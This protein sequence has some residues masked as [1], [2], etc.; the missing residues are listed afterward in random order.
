M[1]DQNKWREVGGSEFRG[2]EKPVD[3]AFTRLQCRNLDIQRQ[4]ST[5]TCHGL[6]ASGNGSNLPGLCI[7]LQNRIQTAGGSSDAIELSAS[8]LQAAKVTEVPGNPDFFTGIAGAQPELAG[9]I[10]VADSRPTTLAC[11]Q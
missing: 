3:G 8:R 10:A 1:G 4:S 9:A 5:G 2:V 7:N 11:R 6:F